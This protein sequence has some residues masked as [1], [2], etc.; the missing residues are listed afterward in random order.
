MDR[1]GCSRNLSRE[2]VQCGDDL[3]HPF[4]QRVFGPDGKANQ[5]RNKLLETVTVCLKIA[6]KLEIGPP[7]PCSEPRLVSQ[8]PR[9]SNR[10]LFCLTAV[11]LATRLHFLIPPSVTVHHISALT[12][13]DKKTRA[14]ISQ[15]YTATRS[16]S[17]RAAG[18]SVTRCTIVSC[19]KPRATVTEIGPRPSPR[20]T[21]TFTVWFRARE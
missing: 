13:V 19:L 10:A 17:T 4:S 7:F 5:S 12:S 21:I 8:A 11:F 2:R 16:S 15:S 3:P 1:H 20:Y 14:G 6:R 9:C 18:S